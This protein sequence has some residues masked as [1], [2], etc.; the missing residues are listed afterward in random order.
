[1]SKILDTILQSKVVNDPVRLF[2]G[3]NVSRQI[4]IVLGSIILAKSAM[5]TQDI[6]KFETL[7]YLGQFMAV[8][9][10]NGLTQAFLAIYP[11]VAQ[12]QQ[13][14]FVS[15]VFIFFTLLSLACS[16]ILLL[17]RPLLLPFLIESKSIEGFYW[18]CLYS[19]ASIPSF[20][21]PSILM[22]RSESKELL[23]FTLFYFFGYI[24]VFLLNMLLGGQLINLLILLNVFAFSLLFISAKFSLTFSWHPTYKKWIKRLMLIGSPLI[25]YSILSGLAPLFDS[26]LV[27]RFYEDKSVFAIYRYGAREFPLTVT[28]A[29][30]LGTAL[31]STVSNNLNDGC[32]QIK[33]RSRRLYPFVFITSAILILTSD[34][35]FTRVFNPDFKS[36]VPVFNLYILIIISRMIYPQTIMMGLKRTKA[37]LYISIVELFINIFCSFVLGYKFGLI[38]I[39]AG[40]LIAFTAEKIMQAMY[41]FFVKGISIRSYTHLGSYSLYCAGLILIWLWTII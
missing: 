10:V 13:R 2:Q 35:F 36:S 21:I 40:T 22:L 32:Q 37:L 34:F 41:L 19:F 38:G 6:G 28:L 26:W 5:S 8:F 27:Q 14:N 15:A 4:A 31:V 17:G 20:L 3:F 7:N 23:K 12:S 1:M 30:G 24:T 9:W 39:A 29:I 18:F 11:K 16:L 25:G 33:D